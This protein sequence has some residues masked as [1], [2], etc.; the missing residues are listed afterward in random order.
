MAQ[1]LSLATW[2]GPTRHPPRSLLRALLV[3]VDLQD[4]RTYV[5]ETR[6]SSVME[7]T[8]CAG[9]PFY[10]GHGLFSL[11][12]EKCFFTYAQY[13]EPMTSI[14]VKISD[15]QDA[16]SLRILHTWNIRIPPTS[17]QLWF[18]D[19]Q[20]NHHR[21][22]QENSLYQILGAYHPLWF[23]SPLPVGFEHLRF[24]PFCPYVLRL[25]CYAQ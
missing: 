1:T 5:S 11:E 16:I 3:L 19:P 15:L 8:T 17:L 9:L 7:A 22:D 10:P 12:D 23:C 13:V 18:E 24:S 4:L 2:L 6:R 21:V 20:G 25:P 14:A